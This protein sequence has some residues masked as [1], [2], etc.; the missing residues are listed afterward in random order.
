LAKFVRKQIFSVNIFGLALG[1]TSAIVITLWVMGEIK[2]NK[3]HEK[4]TEF[5]GFENQSYPRKHKYVP[6]TPVSW[7][8]NIVEEFPSREASAHLV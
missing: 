1:M 7:Q 6:F 2:T 8:K 3:F 5:I 4:I